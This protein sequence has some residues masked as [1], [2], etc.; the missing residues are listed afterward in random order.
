MKIEIADLANSL[1]WDGACP[2][3]LDLD[4]GEVYDVDAANGQL[5]GMKR[6]IKYNPAEEFPRIRI[7]PVVSDVPIY[8]SYL[9]MVREQLGIQIDG[10]FDNAPVFKFEEYDPTNPVSKER[11][12]AEREFMEKA[13][14]LT[15][16]YFD[17]P[18]PHFGSYWTEHT[19][20]FAK[21]WCEKEG[22]EW[23]EE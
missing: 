16:G 9:T 2:Q 10:W 19:I 6:T 4:T 14:G 11:Y 15:A 17:P 22:Y 1:F 13:H 5:V 8:Q 21:E 18:V 23:Y 7:L 12:R 20:Q 3:G